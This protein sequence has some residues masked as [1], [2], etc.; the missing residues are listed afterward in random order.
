MFAQVTNGTYV[1]SAHFKADDYRN[2]FGICKRR[3]LKPSAVPSVF[4]W[5]NVKQARKEPKSRSTSAPPSACVAPTS[6]TVVTDIDVV[7]TLVS[8]ESICPGRDSPTAVPTSTCWPRGQDHDYAD[9]PTTA[10]E[11]LEYAR[12]YIAECEAKIK[13]LEANK[14]S[15]DRFA[16]DTKMIR[17]YTGSHSY[18]CIICNLCATHSRGLG[19][20]A[21]DFM[22]L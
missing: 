11:K 19:V 14:F 18:S 9:Q 22:S 20:N 21:T 6:T 1:C 17:F 3:S 4:S 16:G 10:E 15:I 13:A 7:E 2:S 12:L 5:A 8:V